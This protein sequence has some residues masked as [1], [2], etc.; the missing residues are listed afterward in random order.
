M[1]GNM[2][3]LI[4]DTTIQ[5]CWKSSCSIAELKK[6]PKRRNEKKSKR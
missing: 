3:L 5:L 4:E 1:W 2:I 6:L